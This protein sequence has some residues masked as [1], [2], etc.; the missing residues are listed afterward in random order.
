MTVEE[1]ED[2]IRSVFK[3][4]MNSRDDFLFIYL[5]PT[6]C[7]SRSLTVPALSSSFDW[8]S[9]QVAKLGGNKGTMYIMAQDE[10]NTSVEVDS[11]VS[12]LVAS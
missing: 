11:F 3:H 5:Q 1:V 10:L 8:T 4:P 12:S 6:G 9:Q 7:G 2:E